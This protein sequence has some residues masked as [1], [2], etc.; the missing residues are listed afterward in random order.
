MLHRLMPHAHLHIVDGGGHFA[1]Y[2]CNKQTQ[3]EALESLLA[4]GIPLNDPAPNCD[5]A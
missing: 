4:T 1:Y 5:L 2:V 3:R